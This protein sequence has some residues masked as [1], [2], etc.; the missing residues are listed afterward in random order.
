[1]DKMKLYHKAVENCV[2]VDSVSGRAYIEPLWREILESEGIRVNEEDESKVLEVLDLAVKKSDARNDKTH[3]VMQ[4]LYDT[5]TS[6][7][8]PAITEM[9]NDYMKNV[10]ELMKAGGKKPQED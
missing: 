6:T 3:A 8:D 1:M 9:E 2:T 7:I 10:I 5:L 4:W